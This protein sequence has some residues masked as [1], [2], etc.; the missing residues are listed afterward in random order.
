MVT[1]NV[2]SSKV[3]PRRKAPCDNRTQDCTTWQY[4]AKCLRSKVETRNVSIRN[5]ETFCRRNG[6]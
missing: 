6:R 5:E 3:F 1:S 2:L 4:E